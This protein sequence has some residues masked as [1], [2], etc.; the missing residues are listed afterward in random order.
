MWLGIVIKRSGPDE[1]SDTKT[2]SPTHTQTHTRVA[3]LGAAADLCLCDLSPLTSPLSVG[4]RADLW[5]VNSGRGVGENPRCK[6]NYIYIYIYEKQQIKK[7]CEMGCSHLCF[8]EN[9]VWGKLMFVSVWDNDLK[10]EMGRS[11]CIYLSIVNVIYF[12]FC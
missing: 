9:V 8:M 2:H 1:Y 12:I 3:C 7:V 5:L 11:E 10:R 4:R 6:K